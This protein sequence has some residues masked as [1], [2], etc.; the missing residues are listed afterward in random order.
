MLSW[1]RL[2]LLPSLEIGEI[3]VALVDSCA[4]TDVVVGALTPVVRM[5]SV[6]NDSVFDVVVLGAPAVLAVMGARLSVGALP[7]VVWLSRRN[8]YFEK[9]QLLLVMV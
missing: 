5:P 8:Y 3:V 1:G 9:P 2:L 4:C 6:G 7:P